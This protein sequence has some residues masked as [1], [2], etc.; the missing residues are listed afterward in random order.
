MPIIIIMGSNADKDRMRKTLFL[1]RWLCEHIQKIA[2]EK[3]I[4]FQSQVEAFLRAQ[5]FLRDIYEPDIE[6]TVALKKRDH[7]V[8][9][10]SIKMEGTQPRATLDEETA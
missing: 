5:L 3:G 6:E 8:G 4:T 1:K 10:D 2:D 7:T 9:R